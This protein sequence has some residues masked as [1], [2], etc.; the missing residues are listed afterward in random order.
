[1]SAI[2]ILFIVVVNLAPA[3]PFENTPDVISAVTCPTYYVIKAPTQLLIVT[4]M[5]IMT[6]TMMVMKIR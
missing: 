6:V 1:M 2:F 3:V 4:L 5:V